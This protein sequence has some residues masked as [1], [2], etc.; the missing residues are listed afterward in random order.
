MPETPPPNKLSSQKTAQNVLVSQLL[1]QIEAA[2]ILIRQNTQGV[3]CNNP[4]R[5]PQ[6]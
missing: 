3:L 1:A 2:R 6:K 5:T 4:R